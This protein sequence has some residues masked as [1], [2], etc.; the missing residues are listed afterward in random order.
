MTVSSPALTRRPVEDSDETFLRQL[1]V[2]ARPELASLPAG[3]KAEILDLQLRA[4]REH[5]AAAYPDARHEVITVDGVTVGRLIVTDSAEAI[6]VVDIVVSV[7]HRGQGVAS[8]ALRAVVADADRLGL[9]ITLSVW[10]ANA[11]ARRLYDRLG[12]TEV[13]GAAAVTA[14]TYIELRRDAG[15]EGN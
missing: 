5:L 6:R 4:Q 10:S 7:S 8:T 3:V 1:F 15:V 9:A 2:E 13:A 11:D 14:D 12:F